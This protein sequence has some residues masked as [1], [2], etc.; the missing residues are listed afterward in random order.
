MA[1]QTSTTVYVGNL[2]F[3][4]SDFQLYE[5]HSQNISCT[6]CDLEHS[7][8]VTQAFITFLLLLV[9]FMER[10]MCTVFT[11]HSAQLAAT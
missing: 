8:H 9:V 3:T 6:A 10:L 11:L 1:L 2:A 7:T 4:T 5:V